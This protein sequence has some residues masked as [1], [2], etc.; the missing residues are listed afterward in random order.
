MIDLLA[1][2]PV[3]V[4]MK[5]TVLGS[6]SSGNC[7]VISTPGTTVLVDAG[8]SA[9]QIVL[10]MEAAGY[11]PAA[12]DGILVTHEHSDHTGGLEIICRKWDVPVYA[13]PLTQESLAKNFRLPPKWRLMATGSPFEINDLRVEC[14]PVPHDAVDP[15]GFTLECLGSRLGMLSDIG[16]VT[17][18][19]RDRL[20]QVH[21]LFVEA[22]YDT[23]LLDED[24]KRPWSIKQRISSR[25][26]H[27]SNEQVA[28][29]VSH[30]AH[31]ELHQVVLG[32]L[33]EDCNHPDTAIS[34]VQTALQ[35]KGCAGVDVWCAERK[36]AS[37][38][39]QVA[40]VR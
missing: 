11:S 23:R 17:N 40:R 29:L 1:S 14:F 12:L 32:H 26:G 15:V 16:F 36:A 2:L 20:Q 35:A 28:E 31:D 21:T 38:T 3:G 24:T 25:H 9:K 7:A 34:C 6:G 33:S 8:L 13:T 27:L 30:L 19:V 22:N 4:M 18:L 39:R 37:A 10:R 5:F